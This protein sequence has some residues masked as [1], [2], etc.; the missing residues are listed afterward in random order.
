MA[1]S[2]TFNLDGGIIRNNTVPTADG[3]FGGIV[4]PENSIYTYKSGTVCGNTPTNSY[5][6][7][8]TCPVN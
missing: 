6:T 3:V 8:V 7:D 2:A 1:V 4:S 5:E